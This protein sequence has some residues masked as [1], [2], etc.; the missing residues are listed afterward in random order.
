MKKLTLALGMAVLMINTAQ[1]EISN[2]Q[3]TVNVNDVSYS[4]GYSLGKTLNPTAKNL[5]VNQLMSGMKDGYTTRQPRLTQEQMEQALEDYQEQVIDV[6]NEKTL[7][8][9]EA[10]LAKNAKQ[11]GV[12]TTASG[13][14]YQVLKQ[15]NGKKPTEDN[16]VEVTFTGRFIDGKEF[17]G[18]SENGSEPARLTVDELIDGW[19]EGLQLMRTGSKY[20]FFIPSELAYGEEGMIEENIPPNSVLIFDVELHK[21]LPKTDSSDY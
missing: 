8:M 17:D 2:A 5:N 20:R 7:K 18:N 4:I 11:P 21:V 9:G 10:F 19:A 14:Q 15:G 12:K 13:L 1:A 6:E 3:S 16:D